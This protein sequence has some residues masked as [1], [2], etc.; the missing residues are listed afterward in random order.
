MTARQ[1][2]PKVASIAQLSEQEAQP[3]YA[4]RHPRY[5]ARDD[6]SSAIVW[7]VKAQHQVEIVSDTPARNYHAALR[8][9]QHARDRIETATK[10]INQLMA[11]R[12]GSDVT[13][14]P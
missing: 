8:G 4:S 13:P 5:Q 7:L 10:V 6:L 3:L 1:R 12:C 11:L 14:K 2:K 9:I